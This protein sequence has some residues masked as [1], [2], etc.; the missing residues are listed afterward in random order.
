MQG[1]AAGAIAFL[2]SF[3]SGWVV[4]CITS[5]DKSVFRF[6][7]EWHWLPVW[8]LVAVIVDFVDRFSPN[9]PI[10]AQLL[11]VIALVLVAFAAAHFLVSWSPARIPGD[12]PPNE[13]RPH[14]LH[15]STIVVSV[16]W[17]VVPIAARGALPTLL[18]AV[19]ALA[20]GMIL[21]QSGISIYAQLAGLLGG[22]VLG[23]VPSMWWKSDSDFVRGMAPGFAVIL[24]ALMFNG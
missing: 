10:I 13:A 3:L 5:F 23:F 7:E 17:I 24:P 20:A 12:M 15:A 22:V 11:R 8:A 16:C 14:L 19:T 21:Q 9:R 1:R 4:L 6:T 2:V 18:L